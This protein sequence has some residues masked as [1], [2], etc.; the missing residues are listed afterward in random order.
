MLKRYEAFVEEIMRWGIVLSYLFT[1]FCCVGTAA[2]LMAQE[3][4]APAAEKTPAAAATE[5][6][7]PPAAT[8]S[9]PPA[10]KAK[11]ASAEKKEFDTLLEQ[12]KGMILELRKARNTYLEA[13]DDA[14]KKQAEDQ[15]K[16][17]IDKGNDLLAKLQ[18]LGM[19]EFLDNKSNDPQLHRFLIKI[20]QDA[21]RTDDY[22][23][24]AEISLAM[25]KRFEETGAPPPKELYNVAGVCAY[26]INDYANSE[27]YLN[28]ANESG[29]MKEG[30]KSNDGSALGER[31][32]AQL[33]TYKDYWA[34]EQEIREKEAAA[35]DL[36][37]IKLSTS[38]GDM[39]LELYE[40]EAPETVGNFVSLVE[41]GF[42][43]GLTFHRVLD[44]FMAQGG[45]PKGTGIGDAGYK[46]YCETEKPDFRRHFRGTLS[47]AH[48]GKDTGGSQF[49][50]CFT[51]QEGLDS[52]HTAFGR[53]IEGFDV[54]AK[55]QRIDPMDKSPDISPTK[56]IKAEV[57]RKREHKY[58]PRKVE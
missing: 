34:K 20:A 50:I 54:L 47:M 16:T 33:K 8:E 40:N 52:K 32:L 24:G 38:A 31:Y 36:P 17:L 35:N 25:L 3:A 44:G 49:F 19:K 42:Y 27:K 12:W 15:W 51:P 43:N 11:T 57:L 55:I 14:G 37:R 39:V 10:E 29:A 48:A 26:L 5:T 53:V 30:A 2:T 6:K 41:A 1:G 56:I 22:E 7:A 23:R 18:A 13:A 4:K 45:C 28:L 21:L 9:T 46:I 58:L